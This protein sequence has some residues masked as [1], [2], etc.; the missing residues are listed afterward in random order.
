[1]NPLPNISHED[2][3]TLANEANI[4]ICPILILFGERITKEQEYTIRKY[5]TE[6][7]WFASSDYVTFYRYDSVTHYVFPEQFLC[8][9][10]FSGGDHEFPGMEEVIL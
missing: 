10:D 5:L 2:L 9:V 3:Q 7:K 1:M 6:R 4:R 8:I